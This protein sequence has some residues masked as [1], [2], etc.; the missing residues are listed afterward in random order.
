M[1]LDLHARKME[2]FDKVVL[3]H[4]DLAVG[5]V[6]PL[7]ERAL[8]SLVELL[9]SLRLAELHSCVEIVVK[10]LELPGAVCKVGDSARKSVEVQ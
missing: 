1:S 7:V 4:L 5:H 10:A 3:D 9:V 6:R 8:H 2:C